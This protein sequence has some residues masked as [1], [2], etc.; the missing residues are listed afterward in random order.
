MWRATP[1]RWGLTFAAALAVA[2]LVASPA[3][4]S[5][6][7][8]AHTA[9]TRTECCFV[10]TV[11]AAGSISAA[12]SDDYSTKGLK[13]SE[14]YTWKWGTRTLLEYSEYGGQPQLERPLNKKREPTPSLREHSTWDSSSNGEHFRSK[15]T[16]SQGEAVTG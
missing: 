7:R 13:G 9:S 1:T 2:A 4:P 12:F 11:R 3:A 15:R 8:I 5:G 6:R 16:H 14:S 10:L